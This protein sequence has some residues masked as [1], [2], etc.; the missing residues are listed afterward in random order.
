METVS[1]SWQPFK[2]EDKE[3]VPHASQIV[4]FSN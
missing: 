1:Q 4:H 2:D 3:V